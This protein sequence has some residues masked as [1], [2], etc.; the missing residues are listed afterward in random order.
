MIYNFDTENRS[1]AIAALLVYAIYRSRDRKRFKVTSEMWGQIE[2]FCKSS[3]KRAKTIP[4]FIEQFKPKMSCASIS[5]KWTE[6]ATKGR[7]FQHGE[8]LI[9]FGHNEEKREFLTSVISESDSKSVMKCLLKETSWVIAL[10]RDRLEQ[11]KSIESTFNI[12]EET[13]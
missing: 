12:E 7:L 5:P 4:Q 3:A 6:V 11:E 1:E 13:L 9:D 8:N 2:R 10:V